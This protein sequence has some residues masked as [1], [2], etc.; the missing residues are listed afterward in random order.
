MELFKNANW[1]WLA[2]SV[3]ILGIGLIIAKVYRY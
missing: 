3:L 1:I 2:V